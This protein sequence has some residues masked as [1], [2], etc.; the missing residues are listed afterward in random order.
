M[1]AKAFSVGFYVL[2]PP[3][4]GFSS[5]TQSVARTKLTGPLGTNAQVYPKSC[6]SSVQER[7]NRAR[8]SLQ[9]AELHSMPGVMRIPDPRSTME[10]A[11]PII[12]MI[13]SPTSSDG[14]P[15]VAQARRADTPALSEQRRG[16][17][18][19]HHE[20]PSGGRRTLGLATGCRRHGIK[21]HSIRTRQAC[22]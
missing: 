6:R 22:P 17:N 21:L 3:A 20:S 12:I 2:P 11:G 14:R 15:E 10:T 1:K 5:G 13:S 16:Q 18:S 4:Q 7:M 9:L 19:E 8:L